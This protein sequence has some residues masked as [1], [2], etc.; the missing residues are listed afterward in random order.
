MLSDVDVCVTVSELVHVTVAPGATV[1]GFGAYAFVV[2]VEA[3]E[4]IETVIPEPPVAGAGVGEG[5]VADDDPPQPK[6][7]PSTR[8]RAKKR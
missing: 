6:H 1:M 2:R 8:V 3:P 7:E 5:I 4:T